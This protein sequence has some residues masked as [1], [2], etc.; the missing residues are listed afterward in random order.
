MIGRNILHR[1]AHKY[2]RKMLNNHK[3]KTGVAI[4]NNPCGALD[5]DPKFQGMYREESIRLGER[6]ALASLAAEIHVL[7]LAGIDPTLFH[8][9]IGRD[10]YPRFMWKPIVSKQ[11]I[12]GKYVCK[13]AT[14]WASV[15]G[16]VDRII[17]ERDREKYTSELTELIK[18]INDHL[19]ITSTSD[20]TAVN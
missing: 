3:A 7:Q 2:A 17:I 14:C 10:Q 8:K 5:T 11:P 1:R 16:L 18:S 4:L 20:S 6:L 19:P 9:C 12:E 13:H 15:Y